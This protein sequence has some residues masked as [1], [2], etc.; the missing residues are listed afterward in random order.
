MSLKFLQ[1]IDL[2]L[3]QDLSGSYS[4]D[5]ATVK[6][7][8]PS[9]FSTLTSLAPNT[10]VAA[11][12]YVD[13]PAGSFGYTP[14]FAYRFDVGFTPVSTAASVIGKVYDK[15][16][17]LG[18]GDGPESQAEA[19]LHVAKSV[20]LDFRRGSTRV[21]LLFTDDTAH[22]AGDGASAGIVIP[23][24]YD[25]VLDGKPGGP[26]DSTGEDYPDAVKLGKAL[27][28][29]KITPVFAVTSG[30]EGFYNNLLDQMKSGGT[31]IN[32]ARDSSNFIEAITGAI[33]SVGSVNI[34]LS[35][36]IVTEGDSII[37]TFKLSSAPTSS[38]TIPVSLLASSRSLSL[39]A[40]SVT[41][42]AGNW[43]TGV[44]IKISAADDKKTDPLSHETL[45]F[46]RIT[47]SDL[48]YKGINISDVAFSAVDGEKV[49]K[50]ELPKEDLAGVDWAQ[51]V[52]RYPLTLG[53]IY[54]NL[55]K[56]SGQ[57]KAAFG[58]NH[59]INNGQFEGRVIKPDLSS[60]LNDYGAYV[61]NYGTTL[62]DVFRT[63]VGPSDRGDRK[64]SLF[65]WGKWHFETYG[66]SEGRDVKGGVDW[67]AIVNNNGKLLSLFTDAKRKDSSMTA[68]KF[69]NLNQS[70][71]STTLGSELASGGDLDDVLQGNRV[72]G[73][74][75]K[76]VVIGTEKSDILHGGFGNDIIIGIEVAV[77]P[78]GVAEII[79]TA[80]SSVVPVRPA[81]D[82]VYGGPGDDQFVLQK[83]AWLQIQDFRKGSDVIRLGD[84][85]KAGIILEENLSLSS[86]STDF[87]DV[88]TGQTLATVF[89]QRSGDFTYALASRGM[90][91]VFL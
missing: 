34:D 67:G 54:E 87:V 6:G 17:I 19:L 44:A 18:G 51:Y 53:V 9:L 61:E 90:A 43:S 24:N 28:E 57:S 15:Y 79:P 77:A 39:D 84:F 11:T 59:Y 73:L 46:G 58:E 37:A 35:N 48:S 52:D 91:N 74:N 63:G 29:S 38:V 36:P 76:D 56:P 65:E 69:G 14:D 68:F 60:D 70:I 86:P 55:I 3:L 71:I 82:Y 4:D 47:T 80:T 16:T 8:L 22:L 89:G 72:F 33:K 88:N 45:K 85:G 50:V 78:K 27:R 23:N 25:N 62:L 31:V 40:T 7:L 75:G 41:L 64:L 26:K 30:N 20:D 83:G 5:I 66:K 12:S 13:K 21:A 1:N 10:K 49:T 2:V 42:D 32:L 81:R